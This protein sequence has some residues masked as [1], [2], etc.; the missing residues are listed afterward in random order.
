MKRTLLSLA[1]GFAPLLAHASCEDNFQKWTSQLHP[2]R[3]LDTEHAVCKVW[4]ANEA[5]TIA[6]LPFAHKDNNEGAGEYDL[7]VLVADSASGAV[8]AHQFEKSAIAY[9]AIQLQSL[10]LDTAR[11]QL[12]P[13]N[14][15]F[16]VR[17]NYEGSSRVSPFEATSLSLYTIEGQRVRKVLD[18][19]VVSQSSGDWDGNCEGT[20]NDTTR[21]LD[22]GTAGTDGFAMLKIA[23]KSIDRADKPAGKDCKESVK[24]AKRAN[25]TLEYHNGKYGVPNG[26]QY[27][28]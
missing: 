4:P 27:S 28:N 9:D 17:A 21:T 16:G 7:E 18:K 5:L 13:G 24:P 26:M 1:I 15:A 8:I 23:E 19:L 14:R 6:A 11:Y 2:G 10:A 12:A 20:F 25:I 22:I 3:T